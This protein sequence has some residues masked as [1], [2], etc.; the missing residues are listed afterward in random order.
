MLRDWRSSK[1][2][3]YY[4]EWKRERDE[5]REIREKLVL[6]NAF[7]FGLASLCDP[8]N[9]NLCITR[10]SCHYSQH[11]THIHTYTHTLHVI[12]IYDLLPWDR[13]TVSVRVKRSKSKIRAFTLHL[14]IKYTLYIVIRR[15]ENF[16]Q[17]IRIIFRFLFCHLVESSIVHIIYKKREKKSKRD[18]RHDHKLWLFELFESCAST[19]L[20]VLANSWHSFGTHTRYLHRLFLL[21]P[22]YI[23]TVI[24]DARA[25]VI[26]GFSKTSYLTHFRQRRLD[27]RCSIRTKSNAFPP[28]LFFFFLYITIR[29]RDSKFFIVRQ[30]F[31]IRALH[32]FASILL[33]FFFII[34]SI[35]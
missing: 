11:Y 4:T 9:P 29:F 14:Q 18:R 27:H 19:R 15:S 31:S 24:N 5:Q 25:D 17:T 8:V 34:I 26:I 30:T 20:N 28:F 21:R 10:S 2:M 33:Y 23:D 22:S 1:H 16:S 6:F 13:K 7:L 32:D 35:N 3:A 12:D